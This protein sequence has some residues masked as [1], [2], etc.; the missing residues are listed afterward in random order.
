MS[1]TYTQAQFD[2]LAS[3]NLKLQL[4][5]SGFS[6]F[7]DL[8]VG[9]TSKQYD[10]LKLVFTSTGY[11]LL[12][13][14]TIDNGFGRN[15]TIATDKKSATLVDDARIISG[16]T[17][18]TES[19]IRTWNLTQVMIN[20]ILT[21]NAKLYINDVL[22]T[23]KLINDGDILKIVADSGYN[24]YRYGSNNYPSVRMELNI[25]N[26][27]RYYS[28]N[29]D[30]TEATYTAN[31]TAT[32]STLVGFLVQTVLA[33]PEN[34]RGFNNVYEITKEQLREVTQ[35]RFQVVG[36]SLD[37]PEKKDLGI[38]ILGLVEIPLKLDPSLVVGQQN[39]YLGDFQT[40]VNANFLSVD[41]LNLDLGV[42]NIPRSSNNLLDYINT[43]ALI[44][45]PYSNP[46]NIDINYVIGEEIG[47][48]YAINLYDGLAT[49][50]ISSSKLGDIVATANVDMN[51]KIPFGNIESFPNGNSPNDVKLGGFNGI[52]KPYIEL[53]KN[54]SL[55][56]DKLF[57]IPVTD[58]SLLSGNLG[59]IQ[60]EQ[61]DLKSLASS[62]EKDMIINTLKQGVI[63]K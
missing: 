35:Q 11:N 13:A 44:H 2:Y 45:L 24:F 55:N 25:V 32:N 3:N 5:K 30:L 20:Q 10:T 61:I 31:P 15:F 33:P 53:V 57:T 42:I 54:E 59:F 51:I 50:N 18:T 46:I 49:I 19:A 4:Q 8:E 29:E 63:I 17:V 52:F 28:L 6:T 39:V 12:T 21:G 48:Q 23:P 37:N 41:V 27:Y 36:G 60:V 16:F 47:I 40:T 7:N 9:K 43:T 1:L 26:P 14:K 58:E 62:S 56:A 38:N 34:V 22:A